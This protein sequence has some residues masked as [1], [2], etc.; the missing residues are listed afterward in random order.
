MGIKFIYTN[1][2]RLLKFKKKLY[3]CRT[4]NRDLQ[5]GNKSFDKCFSLEL[6]RKMYCPLCGR[7]FNVRVQNKLP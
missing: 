6:I 3:L 4:C 7:E 1:H 2:S 5:I